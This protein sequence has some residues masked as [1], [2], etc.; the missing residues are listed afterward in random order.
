M[1]KL[2]LP[3]CIWFMTSVTFAQVLFIEEFS[4]NTGQLSSA[5]SG[6]NVSGGNWTTLSGTNNYLPVDAGSLSYSGY[7][8]SNIGNS[9]RLTAS[10]LSSEDVSRSFT[11]TNTGSIYVSFL[12]SVWD[13]ATLLANSSTTGD[14][15]MALQPT[16]YNARLC[17]RKGVQSGSV[18]FGIRANSAATVAWSGDVPGYN[19]NLIVF[20]YDFVT[21]TA[22]DVAN[23]WVNPTLSQTPPTPTATS[24]STSDV[25]SINSIA[26][27]QGTNTP[28]GIIDGI[29]VATSWNSAPLPV[30]YKYFTAGKFD[31]HATIKWATA[32]ENNN[33]GFEIQ[34]SSNGTKYQ[35]IGFV[36]SKGNTQAGNVYQYSDYSNNTGNVCYRLKQIDLNGDVEFSK[37]ACVQFDAVK[38]TEEVV[39][40]P[41][42]FNDK[43]HLNYTSLNE[44]TVNIQIID[45]IGKLYHDNNLHANRGENVFTF[46]T[47]NL[48]MGIYFVRLN[49]NGVITT[50]RI[51]KR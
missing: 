26:I 6:A 3:L 37:V 24:T 48:P 12:I 14:Y 39:T 51:V 43:L 11:S 22:N 31:N 19:T 13:T 45:M 40:T 15:V 25:A 28:G 46:E 17:I 42:P 7:L 35:T 47:E 10:S 30:L 29:R 33:K 23:L 38:T 5:N 32:S 49:N 44:T 34:R 21:G 9:L 4:Y 50:H 1:K 18:Q 27:R 2:L 36:K 16:N 41:N 20:S 8:S